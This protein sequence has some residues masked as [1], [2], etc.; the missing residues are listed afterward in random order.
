MPFTTTHIIAVLPIY[1]LSK[2]LSLV[3]LSIG[4]MI[5]DCPTFFPI[6]TYGLSHSPVGILLYCVPAGLM[7]YALF[8][9]IG[10]QFLIDLCPAGIRSRLLHYRDTPVHYTL[11]NIFFLSVAISIGSATHIIWDA[12]THYNRWGVQLIPQLAATYNLF[13]YEVPGYKMLQ[14]G[15]TLVGLPIMILVGL[16]LI[17]RMPPSQTVNHNT[18]SRFMVWAICMSFLVIPCF[19]FVYYLHTI[20]S[21]RIAACTILDKSF[22]VGN[23]VFFV[24][25]AIYS[26]YCWR[27]RLKVL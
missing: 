14:H 17:Y 26:I 4:A 16:C 22:A 10:K 9:A 8:E 18:F 21:P 25:S 15:S 23:V 2:R 19:L 27:L 6:S 11:K 12:F 13:G 24:Y 1:G 3:A 20:S 5:P 7:L